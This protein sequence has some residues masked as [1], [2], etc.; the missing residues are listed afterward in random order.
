MSPAATRHTWERTTA[1]LAVRINVAI[2]LERFAPVLFGVSTAGAIAFYALRRLERPVEWGWAGLLVAVVAAAGFVWWRAAQKFF[3]R[4]DARI[5]LERQW[6]LDAALTAATEGIAPWPPFPAAKPRVLAWRP[7]GSLGWLAAAWLLL[8][9]S[10][11]LPVPAA[12]VAAAR[13][14]EA[15]PSLAQTEALLRELARAE[16]A[17]PES[18]EQ[19]AAQARELAS[20]PAE[21][22][23]TH[24][25]LEAADTL[26]DQT[27]GAI[28]NLAR[29]LES[30]SSALAPLESA[31]G[32]LADEVVKGAADQLGAALQ[33]LRDGRL[34][35][36][37]NLLSAASAAGAA[38]L[39]GMSPQQL[40]QLRSA[41][42]S[43]A[44]RA[45]GVA[46]AAG[47]GA[48]IAKP[49]DGS[50]GEGEGPGPGNGGVQRGRGDAPLTFTRDPSASQDGLMQAIGNDDLSRAT[51]GDL[52]E[53]SKDRHEVDKDRAAGPMGAGKLAGP[54]R[55]GE[56]AWVDR[57]T[58][59]ERA[60]LKDFFK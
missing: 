53:T 30:A 16:V 36:S 50:G 8:A 33:G 41:L 44:G 19:L 4:R 29:E 52:V 13:P 55:G 48:R 25:G 23:Y 9:A 7:A 18:L 51:I 39:R 17:S 57:L 37:E 32:A 11:W 35:P 40:S 59:G 14:V 60:V 28:E 31:S 58:P 21:E 10:N 34:K 46:G 54:A 49:G 12:T 24:S 1:L 26:R 2:W 47:Q 43:A 38:H 22:Q 6:R 45:R 27:M 56:A 20:R 3:S 5:L 15:P 42:E